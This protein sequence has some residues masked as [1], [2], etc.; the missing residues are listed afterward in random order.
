MVRGLCEEFS[1]ILEQKKTS[2]F[3]TSACPEEVLPVSIDKKSARPESLGKGAASAKEKAVAFKE[4]KGEFQTR[5]EV[6]EQTR[7]EVPET[8]STR[9]NSKKEGSAKFTER[10]LLGFPIPGPGIPGSRTILEE[11]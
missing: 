7:K 6:Y 11:I 10:V 4:E 8:R 3:E 9:R 2:S 5:K 1:K